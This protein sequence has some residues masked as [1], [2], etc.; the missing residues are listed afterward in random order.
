MTDNGKNTF[1]IISQG[2]VLLCLSIVALLACAPTALLAFGPTALPKEVLVDRI[3][4]RV[5]EKII[6]QR[7]YDIQK[8]KLRASLAQHYSGA[9]LQAQYQAQVK[10]LLSQMISQD[11]L[12][13]KAQDL[14]INVDA[15]VVQRLD[16]IRK[17]MGLASIQDLESE[18]EKEGLIWEDFQE[19]IRRQ[20]LT[21]QVIERQVGS[22]I[23]ITQ[24][25]AKKYFEQHK[26][27]FTQP[28][29]VELAEI[30]ISKDK[31]GPVVTAQRA[32]AAL[33]M[34]QNGAKWDDVVKKYS[35]GPNT[36][37]G[38]DVGFFPNGSL[39][40][41]IQKAIQNLDPGDTST[42]IQLSSGEVIVKLLEQRSPGP[43][44]YAEVADQAE[45]AVYNQRMQPA[46]RDYLQTLR[47]ESY[48]W[49][50][51]GFVDSGAMKAENGS[52]QEGG[53]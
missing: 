37:K 19:N 44:Q 51:A 10:D 30:Q 6:T 23:N 39:I 50:A 3:I 25:E 41:E 34:I 27:E 46:L 24:A 14:N 8:E 13:Q 17:Q 16:A 9:E 45:Q 40:P 42:L 22:R 15:G 1:E 48:I 4:A 53:E 21:Q 36:D 5:N 28:A 11:L 32:K 18:V 31:W 2:A 12:V 26:S 7:Q 29:G 47:Q 20:M 33:A 52:L 43:P 49:L 35:D 38:G